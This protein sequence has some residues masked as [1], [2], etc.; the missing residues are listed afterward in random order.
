MTF[1]GPLSDDG[2]TPTQRRQRRPQRLD[3]ARDNI[4]AQVRRAWSYRVVGDLVGA[5]EVTLVAFG[6]M[7]PAIIFAV[8]DPPISAISAI[9][10]T[11]LI[12]AALY[13]LLQR[14][15]ASTTSLI[16]PP[17]HLGTGATLIRLALV[18]L[19]SL[20]LGM[21][22]E[23][24][25]VKLLAWY[26]IWLSVSLT[27]I[28]VLRSA[29]RAF[30]RQLTRRG[31]FD[32]RVA[33]YGAGEIAR[34]VNSYISSGTG[35]FELVGV[36]DDRADDDRLDSHGL[37]LCGGLDALISD[38]RTGLFDAI[39]IAL[40]A[41]ADRRL[42]DIAQR[43]EQLPTSLHIVT[44]MA[45]DLIDHA[46]KHAVSSIGPVGLM[47]VKAHPHADWAP[48][49]K[50]IEDLVLG[51]A[52]AIPL[53][54][55]LALISLAIKLDSRG[56]VF[57]KQR[58][59]GY[60]HT[61]FQ[62]LK[63]RTMHVLEDGDDVKQATSEDARITRVGR[64]LRRSSLDEL[65]QL[66]NV[67]KGEMSLVGPRPHA[68]SHDVRWGDLDARYVNRNQ[69]KPGIT[70]LAQVTGARGEISE[71]TDLQKRVEAD[72]NY[73]ANWSLWLDLVIIARTVVA[74][75]RARNAH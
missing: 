68:V 27:A 55:V 39:I 46:P 19:A 4:H 13:H 16:G 28:L 63:F 2:L 11:G 66:L 15:D 22:I 41:S 57:F 37:D 70:G 25:D 23:N 65:P 42:A 20:G 44:H 9:A 60:N 14:A 59:R 1:V 7:L 33:I 72:L 53:V 36:Y 49:V 40:P 71:P 73:I 21:P 69:V 8:F 31:W 10:Q 34:R 6:V 75:L 17:R 52:I 43:L 38:G 3:R 51:A 56:P 45:E 29:A 67:I 47:D 30:V 50:R 58:R 35:G 24:Y 62:C 54:P 26:A 5:G 12:A 64:W 74:V 18:F 48:I 61:T 32:K